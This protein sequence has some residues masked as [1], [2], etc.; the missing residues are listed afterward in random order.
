LQLNFEDFFYTFDIFS[1][2][3]NENYY[4]DNVEHNKKVPK[5]TGIKV[6]GKKLLKNFLSK[7]TI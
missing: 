4:F 7:V 2:E 1:H 5:K 6:R 3:K